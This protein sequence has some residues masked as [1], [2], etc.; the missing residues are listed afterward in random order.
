MVKHEA[1]A[2]SGTADAITVMRHKPNARASD[3]L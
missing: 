1:A 2:L 3:I